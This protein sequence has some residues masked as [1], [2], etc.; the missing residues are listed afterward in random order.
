MNNERHKSHVKLR[1]QTNRTAA[2]ICDCSI[3]CNIV[4]VCV[5]NRERVQTF[6]EIAE[7]FTMNAVRL[8]ESLPFGIE[9]LEWRKSMP[10][11]L[12]LGFYGIVGIF[13]FCFVTSMSLGQTNCRIPFANHLPE[14]SEQFLHFTTSIHFSLIAYK[15]N[16]KKCMILQT[17]LHT[18]SSAS[19]HKLIASAQ[20]NLFMGGWRVFAVYFE[21]SESY[22]LWSAHT[23]QLPNMQSETVIIKISNN[24]EIE[25]ICKWKLIERVTDVIAHLISVGIKTIAHHCSVQR[26]AFTLTLFLIWNALFF[27][28]SSSF[29][30][31]RKTWIWF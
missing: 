15:T 13:C 25:F 19:T 23:K 22:L 9:H 4:N 3:K 27:L 24:I 1:A 12:R 18:L 28:G 10:T 31:C 11:I 16:A 29:S 8:W 26:A 17:K 7:G 30:W 5:W 6:D 14:T 20:L 21:C 2:A